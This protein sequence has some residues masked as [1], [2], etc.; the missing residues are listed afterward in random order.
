MPEPRAPIPA[1]QAV[2]DAIM[3]VR[4]SGKTNMLDRRA[5]LALLDQASEPEAYCWV[6]DHLSEY[7]RGIFAGF[8]AQ[9]APDA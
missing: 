6:Y 5:V 1:P 9:E 3:A 2:I 7:T 4:A 8:V